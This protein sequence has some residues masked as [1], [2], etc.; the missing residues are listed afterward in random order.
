MIMKS[1]LSVKEILD[2]YLSAGVDETITDEPVNWFERST[3][4]PVQSP[5]KAPKPSIS[6]SAKLQSTLQ[7]RPKPAPTINFTAAIESAKKAAMEASSLE[8]L[9]QAIK[10]FEGCSLKALATSSVFSKGNAQSELM[11]IDRPP[12]ADEDRSGEPF[13]GAAGELLTKMLGAIGLNIEEQY[14]MACLP[15][16]PPG[17]R[18]PTR[19]EITICRPFLERHIELKAPKFILLFGEAAA[20]TLDKKEGINK[21][22]GKWEMAHINGKDYRT[23]SLFHPAFLIEHPAAKKHAWADFLKLKAALLEPS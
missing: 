17:G 21:L 19:E 13:S 3:T 16:R 2:F 11:I 23:L 8:E 9:R 4:R 14:L 10:S 6:I 5:A 22:R 18:M 1:E 20:L 7:N 15:W 12:S